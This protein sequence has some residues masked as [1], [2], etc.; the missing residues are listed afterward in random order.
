MKVLIRMIKIFLLS[1]FLIMAFYFSIKQKTPKIG[2]TES[3]YKYH[4]SELYFEQCRKKYE[5]IY[6]NDGKEFD[7]QT[8]EKSQIKQK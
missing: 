4:Y 3:F 6:E 1:M 5:N 8:V 2:E 7:W